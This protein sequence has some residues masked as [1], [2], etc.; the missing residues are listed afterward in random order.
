MHRILKIHCATWKHQISH[1]QVGTCDIQ[2]ER[3]LA[4]IP[5]LAIAGTEMIH[6]FAKFTLTAVNATQFIGNKSA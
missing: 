3:P 1:T 4:E 6:E 5:H 2:S